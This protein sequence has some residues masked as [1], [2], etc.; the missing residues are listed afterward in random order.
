MIYLWKMVMF[1]IYRSLQEGNW[2]LGVVAMSH[3]D[4]IAN[5]RFEQVVQC[6]ISACYYPNHQVSVELLTLFADFVPVERREC[7][8]RH[9]ILKVNRFKPH[10]SSSTEIVLSIL[11]CQAWFDLVIWFDHFS[12]SFQC[13]TGWWFG[14]FR[15]CLHWEFHFIPADEL[16]F[17][18][19]VGSTTNQPKFCWRLK[20]PARSPSCPKWRAALGCRCSYWECL[21]ADENQ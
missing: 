4:S 6:T 2:E 17:F 18:R 20:G 7:G 9:Q 12:E 15:S 11:I 19:G 8:H 5:P 1:H 13:P 3:F 21:L 14:T 16:P 10:K